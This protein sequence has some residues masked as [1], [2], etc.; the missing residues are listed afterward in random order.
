MQV[1]AVVKLAIF[2]MGLEVGHVGRQL[3]RFNVVQAKFLKPGRVDQG[4]GFFRIHP[5]PG[6]AGGGVFAAAQGL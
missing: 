1:A 5:V 3:G 2:N 4:R 6:G